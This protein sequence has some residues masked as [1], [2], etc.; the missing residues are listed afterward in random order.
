MG[1]SIW[2]GDKA[3]RVAS[4]L[5]AIAQG[6][7]GGGTDDYEE[8][9]N[10]PSIN[11][12]TLVGNK[13]LSDL[14]AASA[15]DL[16]AK[17]TKPQDGIPAS[18]L[19]SGVIPTVHNVPAGGSAGQVLTKTSGTDYEAEWA[20]PQVATD[21]QVA[22]AV[23]DWLGDNVA[24]ETGYVLDRTLLLSNAAAPADL[25]GTIKN[26]IQEL[27]IGTLQYVQN[28]G[29]YISRDGTKTSNANFAYT[30]PILINYG[31]TVSAMMR[32]YS[33]SVAM[34][35]TYENGTYFP[36]V[37]STDSNTN[38]Y[39][40]TADKDEY[41]VFS[42]SIQSQAPTLVIEI[43]NNAKTSL[44]SA[45]FNNLE[46]KYS[47]LQ[48][49]SGIS[50]YQF[51]VVQGYEISGSGSKA[52]NNNFNI[53]LPIPVNIGDEIS[54]ITVGYSTSLDMISYCDSD[55]N[56]IVPITKS[57]D[58][59]RRTYTANIDQPGYIVICYDARTNKNPLGAT[60]YINSINRLN[61][62][63]EIVKRQELGNPFNFN[64]LSMFENIVCC[65]D[66]LTASQVYSSPTTTRN[67]YRTYPDE[68]ASITGANVITYATP[69]TTPAGW[70]S[71]YA[72][73]IESATRQLAIVYLGTNHGLTDTLDTDAPEG[74]PI[75]E[76][77][78]TAT[79]AYA[80]IVASYKNIGAKVLL[81]ECYNNNK[82][83]ITT[84]EV[85]EQIAE[86]FQC[87]LARNAKLPSVYSMYSDL[88]GSNEIHYNDMGYIAFAH[89][90]NNMVNAMEEEYL[91][92]LI[93]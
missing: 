66:S 89:Y 30:D 56:N 87:G 43:N 8:L 80:K 72:Q 44:L 13:T 22:E 88:S 20:T 14:G 25:V 54:L 47:A 57:I 40:Y 68:L 58:N 61:K 2:E 5:E 29:Y 65:G 75:S 42:Y 45:R 67:A 7:G 37:I 74:T 82:T 85:I 83:Y 63:N 6:G 71:S 33:T 21:E 48:E 77:S 78:N 64:I 90:L 70:W 60:L 34:I 3:E 92:Y 28:G 46:A 12:V 73:N 81:V 1:V 84:N 35:S 41:V 9:D 93:I 4:A 24:Q 49:M 38:K 62:L 76:W 36:K 69:G 50:E 52:V 32:G 10:K 53:C 18:D 17:Y 59:T 26:E 19:A 27:G 15:S 86:R 39:T 23:D 31:D 79:G 55:G 51:T 16:S 91:K 11:N